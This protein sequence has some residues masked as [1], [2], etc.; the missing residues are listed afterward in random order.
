L[1]D[2]FGR[3]ITVTE[4]AAIDQV[5]DVAPETTAAFVGRALRGPLNTPVLVHNFGDFRRR[6]GESWSR[7]SLGPAVKLFFDHGG[8][9]LYVV[10]VANNARG[11][12]ICLPAGGSALVLRAVEPGSTEC[13]RAAVDYDG[14]DAGNEE[15]FNLTLQRIDPATG[16]VIDQEVY[17]KLSHLRD[18][19]DFVVDALLTSSMVRVEQPHPTHRP[20]ATTPKDAQPGS[21]YVEHVQDG[22]DGSELS[23]YDLV[24]SRKDGRGLFALDQVD[25]FDLLYLPP[26]GKGVDVGPAALLAAERY[27]RHR[28]AMLIVDPGVD[29]HTPQ[30]AVQAVRQRGYASPSIVGYFPRLA[31]RK[32]GDAPPR[33]V[34]GALAGLL[35]KLDRSYGPWQGL[36]Q[37]GLGFDRDLV[38]CVEVDDEDRQ[39]L[40]REGLN[41]IAPGAAGKSRLQGSATLARGSEMRRP[42]ASLEV[43][44][45]CLR[46]IASIDRATR[47]AAFGKVDAALARQV[48]AQV[49]AYLNALAD[50]GAFAN[51]RVDVQC[52]AGVCKKAFGAGHAISIFIAFQPRGCAKPLSFTLHQGVAGCRVAN[53]A[54]APVIEDCA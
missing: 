16:L 42:F 35:C 30:D 47:W 34:G 40:L 46:I 20:D 11:A 53:T 22:T 45:L 14:I 51:T 15:C 33:A 37:Q 31:S 43:R 2:A 6:F 27:C 38:P 19:D 28:G 1:S 26:P 24:G 32:R 52:D 8:R 39:L 54:F 36:D 23:D 21:A 13:V 29:W 9:N 49:S 12:M 18:S 10:R 3:G 7:S 17:R 25:G 5:I 44:R 50:L 41:L 48:Q 4:V